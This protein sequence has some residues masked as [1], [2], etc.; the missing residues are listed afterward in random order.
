MNKEL[1]ELHQAYLNVF[2]TESGKK[3]LKDLER[4]CF[5]NSSSMSDSN[6]PYR[7]A[8]NEGKRSIYLRIKNLSDR[9]WET[10]SL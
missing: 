9:D 1:L 10:R 2:K 8:F 4:S 3:I 6:D 7:L 5:V